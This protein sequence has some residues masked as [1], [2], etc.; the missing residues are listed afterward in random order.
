MLARGII[1]LVL[2]CILLV[3]TLVRIRRNPNAIWNGFGIEIAFL[4]ALGSVF[5]LIQGA[6]ETGALESSDAFLPLYYIVFYGRGLTYA[7]MGVALLI[8]GVKVVRREGAA[9]THL[10]PFAW[11]VLLLFIA[12]WVTL[13]PAAD[14]LSGSEFE[15]QSITFL[16]MLVSYIPFA[17]F[18]VFFSNIICHS[19]PRTPEREYVVVLGCGIT[20][21]G[22]VTPLLHSR[23]DAG[24]AQWE[25]GGRQAKIICSGGQ[26][27][28]EVTSEAQAMANYLYK[29]GIPRNAVLL[30]SESTT[31]QENLQ[32]S[33]KIID[34]RG[35]C[36]R[37]TVATNTYHCLRAAMLAKRLGLNVRC[38][39]GHTAA[40]FY[41][42]A[43]FR[44]YIA[45]V[46]LNRRGVAI[47]FGLSVL[48]FCLYLAGILPESV[49]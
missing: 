40:F 11:G 26:G 47:F 21:D 8:N 9:V 5:D 48:R 38:A 31:T 18:G 28:D 17:L 44:E 24:I 1:C 22:D 10:L 42:A 4:M 45:L 33:R 46:L 32:F 15:V 39:G 34:A 37:C 43:F 19:A 3:V 25:R 16:G 49:F 12:W 2:A 41:P 13:S 14:G 36:S 7:L 20:A 29:Q 6:V 30:E 27:P 35:G 23:L